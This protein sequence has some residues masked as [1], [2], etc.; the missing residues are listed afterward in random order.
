MSDARQLAHFNWGTL[1]APIGDPAVAGFVDAVGRVNAIAERS[2]GFV[3][4]HGAEDSAAVDAG[5]PLFATNRRVIASFSVWAT[6]TDF[7]TFVY[8]TVHGAFLRRSAEWF[9]PGGAPNYVL[10]WVPVGQIPTIQEAQARV[11]GF[12][13]EGAS[14]DH[15]SL[16]DALAQ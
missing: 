5:W 9:E 11:D 2:P 10:W 13:A 3:W 4:R 14:P 16:K 15:F 7:E 1:R 12:L 6:A 8:K